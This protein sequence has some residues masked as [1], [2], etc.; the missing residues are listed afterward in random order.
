MFT[1]WVNAG[2]NLIAMRPDKQLASLLGLTDAGTTLAEGYMLVNTTAAPGAGIVGETMQYPRHGRPLHAHGATSI[3][4]LYQQRDDGDHEPGGDGRRS[5]GGNGGQAAAF[6]YDLARSVVYTR[7]GNPAWSGQERDGVAPIRSDDLFFGGAP[8]RLRRPEQGR[9]S[10]GRRAAAP[11]G[12]PD[13][14][15]ERRPQAAA[16]VLVSPARGEGG[17]RHDR[18][19]SRQQRNDRPFQHL[20]RGTARAGCSVDNWE[21]VRATSYIY[22]EHADHERAGRRHSRRRASRSA[23]TSRRAAELGLQ[24]LHAGVARRG[25]RDAVGARSRRI[26]PGRCPPEDQPHALHRVERL[27]HASRRS[28]SPMASGST[29]TTTTGR[30][31]GSRSVPA[32]SYRFRNADALRARATAR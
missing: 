1:N 30:R 25:L 14:V 20:Q 19:R 8:G 11:A 13:R 22:P 29:R 26:V 17:R 24:Q 16:A 9:H 3:A 7:Q 27:R 21:C 23:C 12:Q 28:R 32:C 10:A 4:T 2:G 31:R 15:H 18:R 6:T 5:V